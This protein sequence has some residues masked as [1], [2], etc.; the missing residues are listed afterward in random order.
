MNIIQEEQE[1]LELLSF[2]EKFLSC[3]KYHKQSQLK[4]L[5]VFAKTTEIVEEAT[6]FKDKVIK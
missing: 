6:S 4:K 5:I 1:Q 2:Q 3:I